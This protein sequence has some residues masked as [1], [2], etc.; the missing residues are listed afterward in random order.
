MLQNVPSPRKLLAMNR[1]LLR[2]EKSNSV[3]TNFSENT[4]TDLAAGIRRAIER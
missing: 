4:V 3:S 2:S 1:S